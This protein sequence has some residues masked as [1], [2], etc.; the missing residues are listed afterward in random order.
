MKK[1]FIGLTLLLAVSLSAC[2]KS[3]AP[4]P[5]PAPANQGSGTAAGGTS[6]SVD[7]QAVFKQNCISCHGSNLEGGVGPNLQKIGGK[8][9]KDQISTLV[10]SGKGAMPS[11]KG[12]LSDS[13]IGALADWLAAKK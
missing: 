4:A 6:S 9:S 1:S 2:G 7:A 5:T 8:Y 12:R 11:F 10:N 13:E 3:T